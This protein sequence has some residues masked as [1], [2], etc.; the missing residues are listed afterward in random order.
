MVTFLLTNAHHAFLRALRDS[1]ERLPIG[2]GQIGASLPQAVI[3]L[4][5]LVF[6][7]GVRLAAPLI[8]V[9]LVAELAL[10]LVARAAPAL[11]LMV[12]GAP[13]RL[14]L[15]LVLLGVVAPAAIGV[16]DSL[17]GTVLQLGVRA[18]EAFR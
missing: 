13:V 18:A 8:V 4:L 7:F 6:T 11:N 17:S 9:L 2:A 14:L 10:G 5:G 15:G 1:Y 12:V 3:E 16:L